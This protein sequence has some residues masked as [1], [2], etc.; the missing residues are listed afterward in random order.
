MSL[1]PSQP[2]VGIT[3]PI[4]TEF[5]Q[6]ADRFSQRWGLANKAA[7]IRRNTLAVCAVNAYLELMEIPS[8]IAQG[9]SWNPLMQGMADVADLV[10]PGVGV[11][12]CRTVSPGADACH[13]P[14]EDWQDRMG[15][16]AVEIDEEAHEAKLIGFTPSVDEQ[17]EVALGRFEPLE[18]LIDE[19]HRLH[20]VNVGAA[21]Q[22]AS[23]QSI[24]ALR[25]GL[26]SLGQ[27]MDGAIAAS[28]QAVDTLINP[29]ELNFAFRAAANLAEPQLANDVSR[30]KLVDLGIQLGQSVRVA[31]LVHVMEME[32]DN[33][34]NIIVQIRPLG[35]SL[36]LPEGI[37][38][39]ILDE[40]NE[41]FRSATSRE[42]DNYI[43]L[44]LSGQTQEMFGLQVAMGDVTFKEQFII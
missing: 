38:L 37:V 43:Q 1:A 41:L 7:Q 31:L 29:A 28:W 21:G 4:T 34:S 39:S 19:V 25:S 17:E 12:S 36:Y 42:I 10:L 14:P 22:G 6:V 5:Q 27:W 32:A 16:V 3:L 30:V 35:E 9:D 26:T 13:I 44:R 15:Y 40:Q 33:R 20:A 2:F 23:G 18:A 8:A 11:L 24:E